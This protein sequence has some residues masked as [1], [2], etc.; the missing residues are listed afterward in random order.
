MK[1]RLISLLITATLVF[2]ITA[3]SENKENTDSKS[4]KQNVYADTETDEDNGDISISTDDF[5][6]NF[7]ENSSGAATLDFVKDFS[8][9]EYNIHEYQVAE[10]AISSGCIIDISYD[11]EDNVEQILLQ[12]RPT[13]ALMYGYATWSILSVDPDADYETILSELNIMEDG[14]QKDGTYDTS[15]DWGTLLFTQSGSICILN[16]V[17]N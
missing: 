3:C 9:N 17:L 11:S 13:D 4:D 7:S 15:Q 5:V 16:I 14:S 1:K 2:S 8:E 12:S 6:N 10:S